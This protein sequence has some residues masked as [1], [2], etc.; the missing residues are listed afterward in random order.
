MAIRSAEALHH[1]GPRRKLRPQNGGREIN[2]RFYRL[3]CDDDHV[4]DPSAPSPPDHLLELSLAVCGTETTMHQR[5]RRRSRSVLGTP[6]LLNKGVT[7]ILRPLYPV[8][9]DQGHVSAAMRSENRT[10]KL[11]NIRFDIGGLG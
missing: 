11:G 10:S 3:G 4:R 6:H 8:E 9:D 2:A 1:G 5:E 7:E